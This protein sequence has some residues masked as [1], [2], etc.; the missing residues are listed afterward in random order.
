MYG[1]RDIPSVGKLEF[2][3]YNAATLLGPTTAK[4]TGPDGDVGMAGA[5]ANGNN[6]DHSAAVPTEMDYDVAEEDDR[7]K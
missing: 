7:W 3:W 1:T 2:S 5:G 6:S 4:P